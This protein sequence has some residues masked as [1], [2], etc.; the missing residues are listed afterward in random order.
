MAPKLNAYLR[1]PPSSLLYQ[2]TESYIHLRETISETLEFDYT[3]KRQSGGRGQYGNIVGK[4]EPLGNQ[5]FEFVN[6]SKA[7]CIPPNFFNSIKKVCFSLIHSL[8]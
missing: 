6:A 7:G 8:P 5:E 3:Y 2:R 1:L 4:I